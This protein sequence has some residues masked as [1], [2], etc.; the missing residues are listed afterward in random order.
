MFRPITLPFEVLGWRG[1]RDGS[2]LGIPSL[3]QSQ[4]RQSSS[5][6]TTKKLASKNPINV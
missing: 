3:S 1:E 6:S 5:L 4:V 2:L